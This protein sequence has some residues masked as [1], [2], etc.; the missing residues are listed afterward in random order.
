MH[1]NVR[2]GGA[3]WTLA[4]VVLLIAA[5]LALFVVA[6]SIRRARRNDGSARGLWFY[7]LVEGVY[8]GMLLLAQFTLRFRIGLGAAAAIL[9][10]VAIGVGVA[11]LLRVVY[12][13]PVAEDET[14][15]LD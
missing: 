9:T 7:T 2:L 6:D 5:V 3:V 4:V 14:G 1:D 12:P 15:L 8:L 10:P 11:Y 13:K